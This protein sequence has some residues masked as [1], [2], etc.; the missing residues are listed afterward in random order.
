MKD[1]VREVSLHRATIYRM[2]AADEFPRALQIS[3]GRVAWL[4][5]DIEAWKIAAIN[6][7]RYPKP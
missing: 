4:Q 6:G 7:E 3:R 5:S 1:V 2:I